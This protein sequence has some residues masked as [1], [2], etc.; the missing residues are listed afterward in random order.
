MDRLNEGKKIRKPATP[1]LP[2]ISPA[3]KLHRFFLSSS[4]GF[5]LRST[6]GQEFVRLFRSSNPY[7]SSPKDS[8]HL[9]L[10]HYRFYTTF[11]LEL[12]VDHLNLCHY[13]FWSV[14]CLT[15]L[16]LFV[17]HVV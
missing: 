6:S 9:N 15:V 3:V 7:F 4:V 1:S 8:F 16:P 14:V 13:L 5:W 17:S 2:D 12:R 11:G 10:C